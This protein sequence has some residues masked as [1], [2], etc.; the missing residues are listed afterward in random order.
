MLNTRNTSKVRDLS[1]PKDKL[2]KKNKIATSSFLKSHRFPRSPMD[3][4]TD[5]SALRHVPEVR[6]SLRRYCRSISSVGRTICQNGGGELRL[7]ICRRNY[8][9]FDHNEQDLKDRYY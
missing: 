3:K 4:R 1:N 2:Q 7:T 6:S 9:T 5:R 8:L